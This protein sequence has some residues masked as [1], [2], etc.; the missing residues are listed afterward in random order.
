M[1]LL[2]TWA[3]YTS[4]AIGVDG[5][6][7]ISYYDESAKSL[8][9]AKCNDAGCVGANETITTLDDPVIFV[10]TYTSIT[11]G[12]DGLPV[13][14]Y[15]EEGGGGSLKVAKCIDVLCAQA[16]SVQSSTI[17]RISWAGTRRSRLAPTA[18]R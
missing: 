18:F 3:R 9:V 2:T 6:P 13:I 10:G 11:L 14:S 1:I 4:I 15:F 8:K 17:P 5:F 12:A 7:V 16:T